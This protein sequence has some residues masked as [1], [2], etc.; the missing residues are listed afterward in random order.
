MRTSEELLEGFA[1]A[2]NVRA[3]PEDLFAPDFR[4]ENVST[5]VTDRVYHGHDGATQWMTDLLEA[6]ADDARFGYELVAT[7]PD[8]V[9]FR[10]WVIGR[11]AASGAPLELRWAAVFWSRDG[12]LS[13]A[14]GYPRLRDALRAVGLRD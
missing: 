2:V 8:H 10:V 11:G 7:A 14:V 12:R 4:V 6:F 3:F 13:R 5:A 9:V 1:R